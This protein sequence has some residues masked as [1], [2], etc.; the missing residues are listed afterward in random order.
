MFEKTA[1][2][3]L[4]PCNSYNLLVLLLQRSNKQS[5]PSRA[6]VN[7]PMFV[8]GVILLKIFLLPFYININPFNRNN[9]HIIF[10]STS[11][12]GPFRMLPEAPT[13]ASGPLGVNVI[14]VKRL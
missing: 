4:I 11:I 2:S 12:Y 8:H 1:R 9:K 3:R 14:I 6:I 7:E 13:Y 10:M 5:L